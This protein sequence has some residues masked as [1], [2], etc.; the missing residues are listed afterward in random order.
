MWFVYIVQ[1]ND[2]S[3]Y[4]GITTNI[5]RRIKEHNSSKKGAKYVKRRLPVKLIYFEKSVDRLMAS[6]REREIKG[7]RKEKKL[8]LIRL[9]KFKTL[10]P[11]CEDFV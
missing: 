7:W 8:E 1:C 9:K 5:K 11:K 10:R 6:K 3:L 4:T 2:D